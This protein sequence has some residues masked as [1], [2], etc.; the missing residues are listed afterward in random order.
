MTFDDDGLIVRAKQRVQSDIEEGLRA[1]VST[2]DD[3][4]FSI[5][6]DPAN[7]DDSSPLDEDDAIA[8]SDTLVVVPWRYP[9][10]HTGTFLDIPPTFVDFELRG[11]TFI[12]IRTEPW[13]YYRYID[14]IGALHQ[15]GVSTNGRPVS[16]APDDDT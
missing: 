14:F 5:G 12:N 13:T 2:R 7:L 10:T 11:T 3:A 15:I 4:P 6:L 16:T 8:T 9:C 1:M